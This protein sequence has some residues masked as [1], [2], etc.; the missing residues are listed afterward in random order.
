MRLAWKIRPYVRRQA[1]HRA[2]VRG[3]IEELHAKHD[4]LHK[5][6]QARVID[7]KN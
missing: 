4:A 5:V 3:Q 1:E 2:H 7:H 6:L